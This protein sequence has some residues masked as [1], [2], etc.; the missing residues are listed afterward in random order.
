MLS[1]RQAERGWKRIWGICDRKYTLMKSGVHCKIGLIKNRI[2]I[3]V[4]KFLY[5]NAFLT[6]N[7][8]QCQK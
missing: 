1:Q 8:L 7:I 3:L 5:D 2:L 4:F 6:D